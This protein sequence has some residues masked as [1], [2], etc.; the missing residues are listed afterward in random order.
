MEE[1]VRVGKAYEVGRRD[2]FGGGGGNRAPVKMK[3]A[4]IFL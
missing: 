4:Y 3:V 1:R 2:E